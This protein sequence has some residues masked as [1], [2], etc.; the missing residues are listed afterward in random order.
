MY[1]VRQSA[2]KI[3]PIRSWT[4]VVL[5]YGDKLEKWI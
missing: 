1:P 3:H 5:L 4:F 2:V